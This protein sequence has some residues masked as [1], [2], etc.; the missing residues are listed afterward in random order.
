M[1]FLGLI[2]LSERDSSRVGFSDNGFS[3]MCCRL[4]QAAMAELAELGRSMLSRER[5]REEKIEEGTRVA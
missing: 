4:L 2:W 1:V 3:R 5:E